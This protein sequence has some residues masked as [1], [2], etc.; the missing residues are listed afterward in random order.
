M[1]R[2]LE[3]A[4]GCWGLL[5]A[6]GGCLSLC[7]NAMRKVQKPRIKYNCKFA[8]QIVNTQADATLVPLQ[9]PPVL[10]KDTYCNAQLLLWEGLKLTKNTHTPE[11]TSGSHKKT[12]S[13]K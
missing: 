3:A 1:W 5:E 9:A 10:L 4:G 6:A 12:K 13:I 7:R 8:S 2:L 11:N